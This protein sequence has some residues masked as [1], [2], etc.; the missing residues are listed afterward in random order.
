[1]HLSILG[2]HTGQLPK[3]A[4][5]ALSRVAALV[6]DGLS[7]DRLVPLVARCAADGGA[8]DLAAIYLLPNVS[9]GKP[10]WRLAGSCGGDP[11][12]LASLPTTL[13]Q[14]GGILAPLFQGAREVCESD[15]L[16]GAWGGTS[17]PP[18]LPACSLAGFPIRR[19]D[20]RP[21]GV[22]LVGA[23]RP[24]AFDADA[25][26]IIRSIGQLIGVGIDIARLA[27]GQQRERRMVAQSA[28][29]LGTVLESVGSGVCVIELDGTV[30]VAN[31]ALQD[32]FGL[33]GKT[34]GVLQEAVFGS[35][36]VQ[37]LEQR[38]FMGRLKELT[39]NPAKGD[40]SEWSLATEPPRI[41]QRF[42]AP[43]RN[44]AGEVV[45][46][47]EVYT[48]ITESRRLYTQL[49][50]SEKLRA[51]GEMASGV[52]H[53]FNNLLASIVGQ[54]EL[55]HPDDLPPTTRLAI[56]TI[57]QAALDGARMVRNLQGLARPRVETPSR[58][59]DLNETVELAVEMARPRWAGAA[60][61]GR[62]AIE[63]HVNLAD[64]A[65]LPRVGID[66]AELREVLL[67][68]LFNAADAMPDG[69]RIDIT[70][71]PGNTAKFADLEVR[72]TGHGMPEEVRTRIFEPFFSTKGPK[73][74][75]L[76][77]A[78]AYSIISRR[79]GGIEVKSTLGES[80]TFTLSLPYAPI[81]STASQQGSVAAWTAVAPSTRAAAANALKGARILLADDEPGLLA[82]VR[83][84]MERSGAVVSTVNGGQ[85]A[86][87]AIDADDAK[88]DVVITDLD[89][90]DLDGWA[91][92][93]AAKARMPNVPV[94]MLTGWAGEIGPDAFKA[95]GVD[96]VLAKPF[97]RVDLES[98]I[99]GVLAHRPASGLEVLL[100]DD[101]PGFARAVYGLLGLQGHHVTVVESAA[102]ALEAVDA[103][104][105]DVVL[106][107]YSLG[108]VTGAELAERL[109]D[110]PTSPF[111]VLIT[112]YAT[113]IDDP[114]LL[115]RGVSAVLPKPCRGDDLREVLARVPR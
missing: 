26:E 112:G 70:T 102:E 30:R 107:D 27:A 87:A 44:L 100:V 96:L 23:L 54:T 111:V 41:V 55:L 93:T 64:A 10:A 91:V 19:R 3:L 89:M 13:G 71:R 108:E 34:A 84:L 72:D 63:V 29:T 32:L 20:S 95:R 51:I 40:E 105:F 79:G 49:L 50:N 81:L 1:M 7:E 106:T 12:V 94:V 104:P 24:D 4:L 98:A 56:T 36:G 31:K 68:L 114:S 46:R 88:F 48:D 39:A 109:A 28:V 5:R 76:G 101:E 57:R 15:L 62:R 97:S 59:A 67:N 52:A 47:V 61:H 66:P 113:E 86:V 65:A 17:V 110:R 115:T 14:G 43:M 9:G 77:L 11:E 75:G 6:A 18:Q 21:I 53:D 25:L 58:A 82:I 85:A 74:S 103:H 83:Q 69:G 73:G 38:A 22:L 33:G 16:D 99:G 45:G 37:P 90:P 42:S 60:L 78:V 35:A 2:G 80:T 8:A 92:A